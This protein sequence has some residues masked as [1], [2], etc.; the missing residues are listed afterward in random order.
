MLPADQLQRYWHWFTFAAAAAVVIGAGILIFE[1]LPPRTVIMATGAEG[2]ANHELV[3][4]TGEILE[5]A[6]VRLRWRQTGGSR[7]IWAGRRDPL[8]GVVVGFVKGA[9]TTK[10]ESPGL[11]SLGKFFSEPLWLFFRGGMDNDI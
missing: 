7:K 9:T 5:R 10:K 11:V 6:G 4:R 3:I 1:T 8:W 2:G